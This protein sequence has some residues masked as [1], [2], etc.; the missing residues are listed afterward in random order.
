MAYPTSL[1]SAQRRR[2]VSWVL[3]LTANT[4]LAPGPYEQTLLERYV[5]GE[6]TIDQVVDLLDASTF[7]LLYRSRATVLPSEADLQDLLTHARHANAERHITGLLLYREGRYVQVLEGAEEVVRPLYAK[8]RCDPRHTQVVTVSEGYAP[9]RRF[10]HWRMAIGHVAVPAV[11]RLLEAALAER[12]FHGVPID[13][14]VL[15]AFLKALKV[16]S[17]ETVSS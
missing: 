16:A 5:R 15:H 7:Y 4:R 9:R 10:P 1:T 12:P 3:A 13:E 17:P 2:A 11:A 14:H 8:I 6:L